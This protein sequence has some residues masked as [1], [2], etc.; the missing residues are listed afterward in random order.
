MVKGKNIMVAPTGRYRK[1]AGLIGIRFHDMIFFEKHCENMMTIGGASIGLR[2]GLGSASV[3]HQKQ[4]FVSSA[5]AWL[6][7]L[8]DQEWWQYSKVNAWR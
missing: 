4:G 6:P 2:S 3:E 1:S 8:G 5:N 7:D